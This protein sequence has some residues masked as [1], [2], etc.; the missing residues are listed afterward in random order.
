LALESVRQIASDPLFLNGLLAN[1]TA[2]PSLV[3]D[4]YRNALDSNNFKLIRKFTIVYSELV[5]NVER[6]DVD[7]G[8]LSELL[9]PLLDISMAHHRNEVFA[10]DPIAADHFAVIVILLLHSVSGERRK[11]LFR[12][13]FNDKQGLLIN[14]LK[15]VLRNVLLRKDLP[16][17]P[18]SGIPATV[19]SRSAELEHLDHIGVYSKKQLSYGL[20]NELTVRSL[21]FIWELCDLGAFHPQLFQS[22]FTLFVALLNRYQDRKNYKSILVV[23]AKFIDVNY[24]SLFLELNVAISR[25][26]STAFELARR[27]LQQAKAAGIALLVHLLFRDYSFTRTVLVTSYSIDEQLIDILWTV[28]TYKHECLV[29]LVESLALFVREW[30]D[31][32]FRA[33]TLDL[34]KNMGLLCTILEDRSPRAADTWSLNAF[35]VFKTAPLQLIHWLFAGANAA[36][37]QGDHLAA[38]NFQKR[39]A[40]VIWRILSL[41]NSKKDGWS[42]WLDSSFLA[43]QWMPEINLSDDPRLVRVLLKSEKVSLARL[44]EVLR[45][46]IDVGERGKFVDEVDMLKRA[47]TA[48]HR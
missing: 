10:H 33:L 16:P 22:V 13:A 40:F 38:L 19:L 45:N 31:V 32:T 36:R 11:L 43:E 24:R 9:F 23:F 41:I 18:Y 8:A 1:R 25:L 42:A 5:R 46:A 14:L 47:L 17:D 44:V 21:A 3:T 35:E 2:I 37:D 30:T 6:P 34:I 15:T 48:A 39:L 29:G 28:P 26:V 20:L 27:Q 7:V 12:Q 4:L